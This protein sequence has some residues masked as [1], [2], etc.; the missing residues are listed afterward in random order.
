M[1]ISKVTITGMHK[2]MY[3]S[4]DINGLNYLYGN[5][6]AGKSTV[7]QAIQLA[8]LGYI[9]GTAKN[10]TAIFSHANDK[11]MSVYVLF[12]DNSSILRKWENTGKD[13]KATVQVMPESLDIASIISALE[14]P[15]F[16]FNEFS[17]MT[18]NKLKDW[19]I[20]F[21]P[22][23]D[24]QIDWGNVLRSAYPLADNIQEGFVDHVIEVI[25]GFDGSPL[26]KVRKF[27]DLCKLNT[28]QYKA[29]I[30]RLK[31][32]M[33]SLVYYDD[34]ATLDCTAL[35]TDIH[36]TDMQL[37]AVRHKKSIFNK[38]A[39]MLKT[40]AQ[41]TAETGVNTNAE[42]GAKIDALSARLEYYNNM[43]AAI[44]SEVDAVSKLKAN[45]EADISAKERIINSK[46]ICPYT[47]TACDSIN[48]KIAEMNESCATDKIKLSE[49]NTKLSECNNKLRAYT[50]EIIK[51]DKELSILSSKWTSFETISKTADT[52]LAD[53]DIETLA[54]EELGL[55]AKLAELRDKLTKVKS[56]QQ[57]EK[58]KEKISK[59]NMQ[60]TQLLEVHKAWDKLSSVYGLQ[61]KIMEAPFVTFAQDITKYLR[62]FFGTDNIEAAFH[63]GETANSFSFGI[64]RNDAYIEYD[65][66]SSGEKC[67]YALALLL[68]IVENSNTALKLIMID[69]LLDHLDDDMIKSCFTT[70]YTVKDIQI[71]LAGVKPC[72]IDDFVI[73]I[74]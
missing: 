24:T 13:I 48:T 55:S 23:A 3:Q 57:Y 58:L 66:I 63:V 40:L 15:I 12:D 49:Y 27:N 52:S 21:L 69:D 10:K 8:L 2:V 67:L 5:N 25:N 35:E 46:G 22:D 17:N 20:N 28:S 39:E 54:A 64:K 50:T 38:N 18:A 62:Q 41:I 33:Q 53:T 11:M 32:T 47:S 1:K 44:T 60:A 31:D 34:C 72:Q 16:N 43:K 6:G 14:L 42:F 59:D 73:P 30:T 29:E 74:R 71:I 9:P 7:M 19:F 36:D 68:A 61:S 51:L 37:Q 70:L 65:M 45:I 56:N 26:D 4:Y